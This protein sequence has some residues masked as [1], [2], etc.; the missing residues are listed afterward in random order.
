M[1]CTAHE[2]KTVGQ[3]SYGMD[4]PTQLQRGDVRL[5]CHSCQQESIEL[6]DRA[7]TWAKVCDTQRRASG[8]CFLCDGT[9]D[10]DFFYRCQGELATPTAGKSL[11]KAESTTGQVS[12]LPGVLPNESGTV[13]I[14]TLQPDTVQIVFQPCGHRLAATGLAE[15]LQARN[16]R[17]AL[18]RNEVATEQLGS[19]VLR[20]PN[21]NCSNGMVP[22]PTA[23]LAGR[24]LYSRVADW[25][26][27][28]QLLASGG[29]LCPSCYTAFPAPASQSQHTC[30]S[31]TCTFHTTLFCEIHRT[32][33]AS[34][35]CAGGR[36]G[37]RRRILEALSKGRM[38]TCPRGCFAA[39]GSQ[40][41]DNCTHMKCNNCS[42]DWCY[43]CGREKPSYYCQNGCPWFLERY[44]LTAASSSAACLVKFHR[45]KSLRLLRELR[46][47]V[48][49][50]EFDSIF[51]A[52]S[53][54]DRKVWAVFEADSAETVITIEH[55]RERPPMGNIISG[56][57]RQLIT[58]SRPLTDFP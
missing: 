29:A 2:H 23:R 45:L 27:Q 54:D 9:R 39:V 31:P 35:P 22:R 44:H 13:S 52:L 58:G 53:P 42:I 5:R 40:K 48:D 17:Q 10:I 36:E 6:T 11:C 14:D 37:M 55:V 3:D 7:L 1:W 47:S 34:C 4:Y 21:S 20:C 49:A 18:V 57:G 24:E 30:P 12:P 33:V 15:Y 26:T 19:F 50:D 8:Y 46:A 25:A 38:Q 43:F 41:D 51:A 16:C 28:E 56:D 32:A